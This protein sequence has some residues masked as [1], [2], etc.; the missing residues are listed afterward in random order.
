MDN[1]CLSLITNDE[2]TSSSADQTHFADSLLH[3]HFTLLPS[4]T[5]LTCSKITAQ[6]II[7]ELSRILNHMGIIN[8]RA[9]T[10]LLC[11]ILWGKGIKGHSHK[12]ERILL[13]SRAYFLSFLRTKYLAMESEL[14]ERWQLYNSETC[15]V[16]CRQRK[17]RKENQTVVTEIC[18]PVS[19]CSFWVYVKKIPFVTFYTPKTVLFIWSMHMRWEWVIFAYQIYLNMLK[20]V[21]TE[22]K[23]YQSCQRHSLLLQA[24]VLAAPPMQ[25]MD[26]RTT[27]HVQTY[28]QKLFPQS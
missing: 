20:K 6:I 12:A 18:F 25:P 13:E 11:H 21:E 1:Q 3:Q 4:E 19:A 8:D 9:Q 28:Q 23:I 5:L 17:N 14:C 2:V 27:K 24:K 26:M 10:R 15:K 22:T 7:M 16:N